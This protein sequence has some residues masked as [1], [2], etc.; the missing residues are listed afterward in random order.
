MVSAFKRPHILCVQQ[1][2]VGGGE[3]GAAGSAAA[4][5]QAEV[6]LGGQHGCRVLA[7]DSV[8]CCQHNSM[9]WPQAHRGAQP[10]TRDKPPKTCYKAAPSGLPV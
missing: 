10:S 6:K 7:V 3:C 2:R 8:I 5:Q 4:L 1:P 9:Q